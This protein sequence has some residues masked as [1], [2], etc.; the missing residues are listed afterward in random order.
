[1]FTPYNPMDN[2]KPTKNNHFWKKILL[3]F[4]IFGVSVLISYL[5]SVYIKSRFG[6][7]PIVD[8]LIWGVLPY[9]KLQLASEIIIALSVLFLVYWSIR[10]NKNYIPYA[11]ILWSSFQILR[12]GLIVLTPLGIPYS[13]T[14]ISP[15]G[16]N[17]FMKFGAFPSGHLAYPYL[18]Y[19]I[20]KSK[21]AIV[22]TIL[23][24]LVLLVSRGHYSIDL[25]GTF[26]IGFTLWYIFEKHIKNYLVK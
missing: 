12:A 11:I 24:T 26:F 10:N 20:T 8:D 1:M 7:P 16:E 2:T 22:F 14:G 18:T 23:S 25:I 6:N 5:A 19:L 15:I 4:I 13:Y 21:L 17:S 9:I 3:S